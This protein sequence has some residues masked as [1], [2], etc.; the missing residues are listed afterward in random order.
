MPYVLQIVPAFPII[1]KNNLRSGYTC[2]NKMWNTA[3]PPTASWK[4]YI[5]KSHNEMIAVIG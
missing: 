4:N 5:S 3:L 1:P 2:T